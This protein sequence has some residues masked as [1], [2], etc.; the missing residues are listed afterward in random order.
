[1]VA[2]AYRKVGQTA[3]GLTALA[4]ALATTNKTGERWYEAE[5]YRVKGELTLQQWKVESGKYKS[6][7]PNT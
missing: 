1:M 7:A 2:E 3:E 4:E 6:L 5:L